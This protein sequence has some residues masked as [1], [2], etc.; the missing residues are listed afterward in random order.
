LA[1]GQPSPHRLEN[2][3]WRI[4]E[5]L[6]D[7]SNKG[8][9]PQ[10]TKATKTAEITFTQG[11]IDG[12]PTCGVLYGTYQLSGDK[13]TVQANFMLN[14]RCF[15]EQEAQNQRVL[16]AFRG[17]L[18]VEEQDDRIVLRDRSGQVRILLVHY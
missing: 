12:S 8:D 3:R 6:A 17:L 2:R 9:Q 4:A 5:Y 10:L 1:A 13:L 14:G 11:H 18:R 16:N 15:P 7:E